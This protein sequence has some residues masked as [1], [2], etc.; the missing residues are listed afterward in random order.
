VGAACAVVVGI[1]AVVLLLRMRKMK[2]YMRQ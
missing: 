2:G 1:A